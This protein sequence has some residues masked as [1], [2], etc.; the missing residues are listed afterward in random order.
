MMKSDNGWTPV[1]SANRVYYCSPRCGG[2]KW[3]RREWYEAAVRNAETLAT[4]MGEGWQAKVWENLGWHYSVTKGAATIH[5]SENRRKPF[6]P[7]T[8]YPVDGYSAWISPGVTVGN[9]SVQFI[10][11]AETPED[12]LGFA[13]QAART[14]VSRLTESLA[15]ILD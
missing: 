4:R 9:Q 7:P 15:E 14:F 3:C 11:T 13:T 12:A 2:G 6:D 8:G 5:V 1:L 10:E